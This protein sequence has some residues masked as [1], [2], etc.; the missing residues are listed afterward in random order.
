MLDRSTRWHGATN[1]EKKDAG[2]LTEAISSSWLSIHGPMTELICDGEKAIASCAESAD[3]FARRGIKLQIR[4]PGQHARLV[5][6][7]QALLR[8]VL[9]RIDTQLFN[10]GL[11][12]KVPFSQRL[13]E[14]TFSGNA[15]ISINGATPYSA[16]YGRVP[17][18]LPDINSALP[19]GIGHDAATRDVNR[20]REV[21]AQAIIEATSRARIQRALNTRTL[22][23]AEATYDVGME[24]EYYREPN[25]KDASGWSGPATVISMDDA[26][27]GTIKI[28]TKHKEILVAPRDLRPA[29]TY[30]ALF[31]APHLCN[32]HDR[33]FQVVRQYVSHL[34]PGDVEL[35]GQTVQA[36]RWVTTA[37]SRTHATV[38]SALRFIAENT[39]GLQQ[40][41]AFACGRENSFVPG[42]SEYAHALLMTWNADEPDERHFHDSDA[43]QKWNLQRLYGEQWKR[44]HWIQFLSEAMPEFAVPE[45][46]LGGNAQDTTVQADSVSVEL[47]ENP[48]NH[49]RLETIFEGS[50]EGSTN[51]STADTL[52]TSNEPEQILAAIEM[53]PSDGSE[54]ESSKEDDDPAPASSA[55]TGAYLARTGAHDD[56]DAV[57]EI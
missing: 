29:T 53:L 54:E 57:A 17:S 25:N 28:K 55:R 40:V 43:R 49:G 35:F 50:N 21:S 27:R 31:Q 5:E 30:L 16:V 37:R 18:I 1:V 39:L 19:D 56:G 4:A 8:D 38:F 20:V 42:R 46:P 48:I 2:T 36:R 51:G 45:L 12:S 41:I 34:R 33:A 10:D 22:A 7:R 26:Q 32:P 3:F 52:F 14:A 15:L 11:L 47:P 24:V 6:R 44:T 13:S 23:P 9:H